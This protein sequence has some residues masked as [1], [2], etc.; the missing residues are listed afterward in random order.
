[1]ASVLILSHLSSTADGVRHIAACAPNP[2]K[3]CAPLS[4][5]RFTNV[6]LVSVF[7]WAFGVCRIRAAPVNES[8]APGWFPQLSESSELAVGQHKR[9]LSP[10]RCTN[11]GRSK[12]SPFRIEPDFGKLSEYGCACWKIENWRDVLKK[13]PL[14]GLQLA[15]ESDNSKEQSASLSL[16]AGL[17]AGNAEVLAG[18]PTNESSHAA[19]EEFAWEGCNVRPDRRLLQPSV[20]HASRQDCGSR[21]FPLHETDAASLRQ[22]A[23]DGE[24]ESSV[25]GEQ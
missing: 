17:S 15:N 12:S 19:T 1:M 25:A 13:Q 22:S 7:S 8:T 2:L 24:V 9:P 6:P 14:D 21:S 5:C 20:F 4:A 3:Q 16:N 10:V 23:S 18:E 11:I